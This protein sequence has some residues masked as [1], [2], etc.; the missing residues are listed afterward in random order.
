MPQ[1][2][3][4]D[5]TV[6]LAQPIQHLLSFT[7][8]PGANMANRI[9]V[10]GASGFLGSAVIPRLLARGEEVVGLDPAAPEPA[11]VRHIEDDLSEPARVRALLAKERITHILHAGGVSGPMV[12]TDRP[13]RVM[14]IN[15]GASLNLLLAALEAGVKTFVY[16]SSVSA[17]GDF[18]EAGPIDDDYPM[19]P[20]TPYGSSQAAMDMVLRGLW[21]KTPLDLCSLR[22][23]GIY[24]SARR[25]A[26]AIGEIVDAAIEGRPAHVEPA[27]DAPFIYIDDAA[28]AAVAAC[29]SDRRRQLHYFLAHPEQVALADLAAAAAAAG[30]PVKIEVDGSLKPARRG[31]VDVAPAIRDFGFAPK[32]DHRAGMARMIAARRGR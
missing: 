2:P 1:Q 14:A 8:S 24:G 12:M 10:T 15:V 16:C 17:I 23:T 9:L 3:D 30:A 27:T 19:R 18:Y 5:L 32:V 20:T 29:L 4:P 28:D 7:H 6:P 22:F 26:S 31:P 21:R 25:T 13:D 11:S